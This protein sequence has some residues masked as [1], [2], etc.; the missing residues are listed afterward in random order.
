MHFLTEMKLPNI[1]KSKNALLLVFAFLTFILFFPSN[2]EVIS[3]AEVVVGV[4]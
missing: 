4:F 2:L 1:L 3:L